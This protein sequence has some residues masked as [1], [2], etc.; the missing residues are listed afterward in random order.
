V[1]S[2][3]GTK[4]FEDYP[5]QDLVP[6]IDWTP[7]FIAWNLSGR[8]P[9]ILQDEVVGEAATSLFQDANEML[10]KLIDEKLVQARAVIGFWPANRVGSDDIHIY[11][12]ETRQQVRAVLSHVR[13]Q[14]AKVNGRPNLSLADFVAPAKT[15]PDYVGGFVVTAGI[16]AQALATRF[17]DRGDD[18]SSIMVKALTDRL[19]EAFAECMHERVRKTF[20]G[21]SAAEALRNE[22]LIREKYRGI[23]P[24]PGYPACPDHTEKRKL[25]D[26]L[27]AE[28][29][30]GVSL[31]EAYAML[32]AAS[33]SGWYFSHPE[34]SYFGIGKIQKDQVQDLARRKKMPVEELE[35]WLSPVL[36]Y[37]R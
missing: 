35:R 1:P 34:S 21:Y 27:A 5:L 19:A 17:E 3:T 28:G 22:E 15:Q 24:A 25:F 26:L 31:T 2:F 8:Y 33:V 37:D 7:F 23:R 20:W 14:T 12:D 13:Q 36:D 30:T 10:T 9:Q 11:E 16:G 18:Y 4:V 6:Y 32:P 29:D